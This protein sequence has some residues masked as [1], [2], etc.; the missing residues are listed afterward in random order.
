MR[1]LRPEKLYLTHYGE[2]LDVENHFDA[3]EKGLKAWAE[4]MFPHWKAQ[5]PAEQI[6]PQFQAY[7]AQS[8]LSAGV[9]AEDLPRYEAA[10]PA[11]MSVAG[12]L[13]YFTKYKKDA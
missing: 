10:N 5:T 7:V 4:W 11:W 2:V 3:L 13:R 6:T 8:L 1:G 12:L 9:A